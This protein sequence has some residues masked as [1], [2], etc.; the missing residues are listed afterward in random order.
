MTRSFSIQELFGVLGYNPHRLHRDNKGRFKI[1]NPLGQYLLDAAR[2]Y[3][4]MTNYRDK[5]VLRT[6]LTEN[7][8]LHPR[9][10]LDQSYYWMLKSTE[11]RDRDQVFYRST[12]TKPSE[13]HRYDP[14]MGRWI[15][16][17]ESIVIGDCDKCRTNIQRLSRI[18]MVDQL[19]MWILDED[20]IITCFPECYGSDTKQRLSSVHRAIRMRLQDDGPG[21][22]RSVYDLALIILGE[23]SSTLFDRSKKI[24]RP[25]QVINEY[26]KVIWICVSSTIEQCLN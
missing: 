17:E 1:I 21:Q 12:T 3:E 23:C 9:R 22:V 14:R 13:F 25:P 10:T 18:I 4:G 26:S 16:H 7:P 6:Y 2:L 8:P 20:T 5:M 24:D 11:K 19:W 15:E